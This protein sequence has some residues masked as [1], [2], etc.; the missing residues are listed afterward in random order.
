MS[1][2][3]T[4]YATFTINTHYSQIMY[5]CPVDETI[6]PRF[7]YSN[8]STRAA[9]SFPAHKFPHTS[10]I[11]YQC[12]VRL[13]INNGGCEQPECS[14]NQQNANNNN[15]NNGGPRRKRFVA[16]DLHS[17][18]KS[19]PILPLSSP[20][21]MPSALQAPLTKEKGDMSFDVYS[22]LYV[23][24]VDVAGKCEMRRLCRSV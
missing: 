15:N 23:D 13:C 4:Q 19:G 6:M 24:D 5:S 12:N 16:P 11:Y 1:D 20:L 8:N 2:E 17:A 9:V 10:S 3:H 18:A 7:E 21:P 22:G 14:P